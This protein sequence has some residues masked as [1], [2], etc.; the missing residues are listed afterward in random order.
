LRR[1]KKYILDITDLQFKQVRIP[2]NKMLLRGL[3]FFAI[4][5]VISIF[6]LAVF[7]NSFG[8]L[9]E[10]KLKQDIDNIQLQYTM[11]S[12]KYEQAF[13]T[14]NNLRL[15]DDKR[16]R[17]ILGMDSIPSSLRNPA[18]GGVDRYRNLEGFEYSPTIIQSHQKLDVLTNLA[19]M[20]EESFASVEEARKEWARKQE[21]LP[22]ICPVDPAIKLG[23]GIKFRKEHPVL[24]TAR[25]HFGQD[26]L[27][28][29]GTEVYATGNG[30]I[31]VAAGWSDTGFG[32]YIVIDHGYGYES[33]YGHLSKINVSVGMNVKRGDLIGLSG[34]TGTSSGPHL[35]YQ[36]N[37]NGTHTN[38]LEFF[39]DDLTSEEYREMIIAMGS[40][41]R[42]R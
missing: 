38:V 26:F 24:G 12:K 31:T 9:K 29:Y 34:N 11:L 5:I 18:Y 14:M 37:F 6:Y 20:Q 41:S 17:P 4:S 8:S 23:D 13:N 27:A 15:S 40:K 39:S 22:K 42:Y 1:N 10:F 33:I 3:M 28:P 19:R 21:Y 7:E 2:W 16:Y 32:S 30:S 25:W 36:I 35:H